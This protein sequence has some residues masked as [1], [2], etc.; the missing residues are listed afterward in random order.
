MLEVLLPL[1]EM[2]REGTP[3]AFP[4]FG[5]GNHPPPTGAA[6]L[7][8]AAFMQDFGQELD[9]RAPVIFVINFT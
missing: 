1:H 9:V 2:I 3:E 8:E 4:G 7:S 5:D 6:T